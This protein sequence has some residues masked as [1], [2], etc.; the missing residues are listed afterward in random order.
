[1][2]TPDTHPAAEPR[3][4]SAAKRISI[5]WTARTRGTILDAE[6]YSRFVI[7]MK[8]ALPIAAGAVI[9]AVV[10]YSLVPRP[11]DRG[12]VN[13]E[14]G[15]MRKLDNDLAMIKPRLTGADSKGN[16]FV[17]TADA[18]IQDGKNARRA[19]LK[20]VEADLT[21][22]NATWI[23]ANAAGGFIDADKQFLTLDGGISVFSDSGYELHT[24]AVDV[25]LNKS[26]LTGNHHVT[27]QGPQGAFEADRFT[28]DHKTQH[29]ALIGN[30]HTTLYAG[31]K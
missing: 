26:F 21:T 7:V 25:D 27:G 19:R 31:K 9:M 10:A 5:D 30:V 8:R 17:I 15:S 6:R 11:S 29:I 2:A 4:K 18:A 28:I 14:Y 1:V 13:F 23:N 12:G 16:P 22:Q 20:N 3:V 24:S